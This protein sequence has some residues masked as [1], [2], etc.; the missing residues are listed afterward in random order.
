MRRAIIDNSTLTAVQRLMGDI[1]ACEKLLEDT[2]VSILA[3]RILKNFGRLPGV[4]MT[5]R[6]VEAVFDEILDIY[7]DYGF[8]D[9]FNYDRF[10]KI[11]FKKGAKRN[12]RYIW[13]QDGNVYEK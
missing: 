12:Q 5:E 6:T 4:G 2:D 1:P 13:I 10:W 11:F 7:V 9:S 3:K 8:N